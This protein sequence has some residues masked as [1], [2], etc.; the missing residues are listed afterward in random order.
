MTSC[1]IVR[2]VKIV[3]CLGLSRELIKDCKLFTARRH[4]LAIMCD[5]AFN[6]NLAYIRDSD[7]QW[8]YLT[9]ENLGKARWLL[10]SL[11]GNISL[12]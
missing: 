6:I 10:E 12:K 2:Y 11:Q 7:F 3:N 8:G 1:S 5:A 4:V 9:A